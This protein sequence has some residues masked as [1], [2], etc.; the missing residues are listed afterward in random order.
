MMRSLFFPTL[1]GR[2]RERERGCGS[3]A[4]PYLSVFRALSPLL[5]WYAM[6]TVE[7]QLF[8]AMLIT[9]NRVQS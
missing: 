6:G 1:L 2:E 8:V 5:R 3:S 7:D 9:Q 4:V